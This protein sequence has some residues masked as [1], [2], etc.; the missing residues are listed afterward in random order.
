MEN[1]L[2]QTSWKLDNQ[3][4]LTGGLMWE[5][6]SMSCCAVFPALPELN[7]YELALHSTIAVRMSL[8]M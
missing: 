2:V 6:S 1:P 3:A 7:D 5:V 4:K 8:R